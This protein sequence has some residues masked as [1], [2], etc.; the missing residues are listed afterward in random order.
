[1]ID[2]IVRPTSNNTVRP[3]YNLYTQ[4]IFTFTCHILSDAQTALTDSR[5]V[6][7]WTCGQ[8]GQGQVSLGP[9]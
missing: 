3:A 9:G 6:C 2:F 4:P 5:L 8:G 7:S 1:M